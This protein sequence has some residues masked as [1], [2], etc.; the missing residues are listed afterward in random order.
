MAARSKKA[1]SEAETAT[2]QSQTNTST[3]YFVV[4]RRYRPQNF[5]E[6]VGQEHVATALKNAIR[7]G[8][9]GH[10]Y[11]F[12]GARGV[13][14]TST[15]RILAKALNCVK[16]PTPE[17]CNECDICRSISAGDDIDVVEID[18]ASNRGIEEIRQLRQN[19]VIRPSRCRYKIYIIDEVH[20]LTKEAFNAL[21]KTLEEPPEHV[22]FIFCTTEPNKVPVTILS[23]CQRFDFSG[24]ETQTIAARL[25]QIVEAEGA[26]VEA[27]V[28][29]LLA[30]RAAGS[31]RDAQSLLEQLLSFAAGKITL[32]DVLELLG[33]ARAE[34]L[35]AI[36]EAALKGDAA[37]ALTAFHQALKDGAD[38]SLLLEQLL[39]YCRDCM[40]ATLGCP[41]EI[42]LSVGPGEISH[43]VEIGNLLGLPRLLAAMQI[44]DHALAR[45]RLAV[46]DRILG[47][48]AIVRIC[49]LD[50]LAYVGKLIDSLREGKPLTVAP[51]AVSTG[52][53]E[54]GRVAKTPSRSQPSLAGDLREILEKETTATPQSSAT[55]FQLAA[56]GATAI[57]QVKAELQMR[58]QDE[59]R[60]ASDRKKTADQNVREPLTPESIPKIWI[61]AAES[62]GGLAADQAKQ[63][64]QVE[65]V[66]NNRI[67]VT[68][69]KDKAFCKDYCS[70]PEIKARFEQA[71]RSITGTKLDLEMTV[72]GADDQEKA[73]AMTSERLLFDILQEPFVRKTAEIFGAR[74]IAVL[75]PDE[76]KIPDSGQ[77]TE[78]ETAREE[79]GFAET[80]DED[81]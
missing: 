18:G 31:M 54:Q 71:L 62:V 73:G 30:R 69:R 55:V 16:G 20:M 43:L 29:D 8:R 2:S 74:P 9:V 53:Q 39:T 15:A 50:E 4:A 6:L 21:L 66:G 79:S 63:F 3:G 42:L 81:L 44:L 57:Q 52:P 23:R 34:V 32:A 17:P 46:H 26:S 27:G 61:K 5:E 45:M 1:K 49:R 47:E 37:Q 72:S 60:R 65:L 22:K 78:P 28:L 36:L 70:H 75:P 77:A 48:L 40:V 58:K 68:F 19:V 35:K 51:A 80:D 7:S 59:E 13:G 33:M 12:T 10:A 24:I 25:Q 41:G 11:L 76:R 67:I 14:K 38:P 56:G 64:A